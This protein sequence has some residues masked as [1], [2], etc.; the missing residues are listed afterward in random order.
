MTANFN[1]MKEFTSDINLQ[2]DPNPKTDPGTKPLLNPEIDPDD[3]PAENPGINPTTNPER[4]DD[5]VDP[6]DEPEIGD[7]PSEEEKK[8][9][10]F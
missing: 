3:T 4:Y 9:P 2:D 6:F 1:Q 10:K 8:I 7:D 5:D